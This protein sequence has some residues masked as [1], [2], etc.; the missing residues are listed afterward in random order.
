[1]SQTISP[2]NILRC[3]LCMDGA[4]PDH[5]DSGVI[6]CQACGQRYR[7]V[8]AA[9]GQTGKKLRAVL[10][11]KEYEMNSRLKRQE[12]LIVKLKAQLEEL[13]QA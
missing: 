1:M 7:V 11:R 13:Q 5:L 12:T 9:K 3:P 4:R 2:R 10:V 8:S 6:F